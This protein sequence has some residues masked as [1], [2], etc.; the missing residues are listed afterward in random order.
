VDVSSV[1]QLIQGAGV[2]VAAVGSAATGVKAG[3]RSLGLVKDALAVDGIVGGRDSQG[4]YK[5]ATSEQVEALGGTGV[6]REI[7]RD[8]TWVPD[9]DDSYI[10][11]SA[12]EVLALGPG[13]WSV[14]EAGD[15]AWIAHDGD[16][17]LDPDIRERIAENRADE[18][19]AASFDRAYGS[20]E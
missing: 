5:Y 18:A 15:M 9:Q 20:G 2:A 16:T 12:E 14:D 3:L 8:M 19:Y 6:W 4:I 17:T 1:M 13:H 11:P 10:T 7:D